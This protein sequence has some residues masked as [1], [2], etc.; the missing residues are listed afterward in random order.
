[1]LGLTVAKAVDVVDDRV[2]T[3]YEDTLALECRV[4]IPAAIAKPLE[5]RRPKMRHF[6]SSIALLALVLL[7]GLPTW[8]AADETSARK[9]TRFFELRTYTTHPGKLPALHSRFRDHT[10]KLFVKHG[11]E[12]VGYWT[13]ADGPE[14]ENTL[15]YML[16]YSSH[17]ARD[18]SWKAFLADT[19]WQKAF[20]QSHKDAGG[21]IVKKVVSKFLTPTDYSPIK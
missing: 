16:A 3:A 12:L 19:D 10:N 9:E 14:S 18:K 1:V 17:E 20:K 7:G 21:P 11:M 4:C 15:T 5:F 2:P 8:L 6:V 13:P